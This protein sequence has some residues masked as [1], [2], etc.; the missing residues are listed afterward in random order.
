MIF[1]KLSKYKDMNRMTGSCMS[2]Y[3][4]SDFIS[5]RTFLFFIIELVIIISN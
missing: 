2:D 5:I 4:A 1:L 3:F